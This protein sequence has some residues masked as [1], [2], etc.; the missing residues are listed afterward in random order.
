M[1]LSDAAEQERTKIMSTMARMNTILSIKGVDCQHMLSQ[2]HQQI[3]L[4]IT[5]LQT[6][7]SSAV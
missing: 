4:I 1:T 6:P 5:V 2:L 7:T 3:T